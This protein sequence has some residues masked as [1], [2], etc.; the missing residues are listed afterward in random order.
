MAEIVEVYEENGH[1]MV[2]YASGVIRDETEGRIACPPDMKITSENAHAMHELRRKKTAA[3]LREQISTSVMGIGIKNK[4]ADAMAEVGG[5]LFREIVM[6]PEALARDRL[7]A[8]SL[9][10]KHAQLLNDLREIQRDTDGVTVSIG[11]DL[12]RE[13]V[14]KLMKK[15]NE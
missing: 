13:I 8:F 5:M 3:K 9:I 2:K 14:E 4:S 12:A 7:Q 10:G 11:K 15:R 1:K 6:N